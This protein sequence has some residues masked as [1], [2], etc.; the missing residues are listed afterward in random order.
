MAIG[1]QVGMIDG[2][3]RVTGTIGYAVNVELPGTL[4]ARLVT[5]ATS[6]AGRQPQPLLPRP[7][8]AASQVP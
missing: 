6:P 7:A 8:L 4:P 2:L 3:Q 1:Q 5:T